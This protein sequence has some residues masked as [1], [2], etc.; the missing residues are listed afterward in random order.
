[1]TYS[2][3]AFFCCIQLSTFLTFITWMLKMETICSC[4][5]QSTYQIVW[6]DNSED[7]NMN[8]YCC[9]NIKSYSV[10]P[11]LS[12]PSVCAINKVHINAINKKHLS[13]FLL[14]C[15]PL[16]FYVISNTR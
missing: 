5:A 3:F 11:S 14:I 9:E 15:L 2:H 1:M 6:C 7:Q 8:I 13:F 12:L 10:K 4:K 16:I